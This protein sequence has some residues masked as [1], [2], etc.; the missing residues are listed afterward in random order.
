MG[1][2]GGES[3]GEDSPIPEIGAYIV[4]GFPTTFKM[5]IIDNDKLVS[6]STSGETNNRKKKEKMI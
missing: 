4:I 3:D 6:L 2:S 1:F 5:S